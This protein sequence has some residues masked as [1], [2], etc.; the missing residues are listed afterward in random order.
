MVQLEVLQALEQM[1]VQISTDDRELGA[2]G[3]RALVQQGQ[4]SI[5]LR[6]GLLSR[7]CHA[8]TVIAELKSTGR[9]QE[10]W[11]AQLRFQRPDL[12][13]YGGLGDAQLVGG[14]RHQRQH[15]RQRALACYR[16][17]GGLYSLGYVRK[18]TLLR[19]STG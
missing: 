16:R 11:F 13:A 14:A 10:Q 4:S 5:E 3:R 12:M 1:A 15:G 9:A 18:A 8:F 19:A 6:E 2:L 7:G 17:A